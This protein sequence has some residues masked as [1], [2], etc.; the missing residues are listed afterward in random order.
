[1]EREISGVEGKIWV[2]VDDLPSDDLVDELTSCG[3]LSVDTE[4]SGLSFVRDSLLLVQVGL[5]N[6]DVHMVK[7]EDRG[8]TCPRLCRVLTDSRVTKIFH[9]ARFDM[10]IVLKDLGVRVG[11]IFCTKIAS[12]LVRTYTSDHGL[13]DLCRDFLGLNLDKGKQMSDWGRSDLS[14][15]QYRYAAGDVLHLQE[16]HRILLEMLRREG[17]E[18]LARECFGFLPTRVEL[19][20][21]GWSDSDIFSHR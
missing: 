14:E 20:L 15:D 13:S 6:G 2:H 19:D 1:M 17:R 9:F 16:L 11:P 4:T 10:G 5:P 21:R 8:G 3:V 18:E 12:K 7:R